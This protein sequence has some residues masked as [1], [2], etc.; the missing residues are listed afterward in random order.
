MVAYPRRSQEVHGNVLLHRSFNPVDN[1][2]ML[3]QI[4]YLLLVH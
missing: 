1:E 3:G 2:R 4:K